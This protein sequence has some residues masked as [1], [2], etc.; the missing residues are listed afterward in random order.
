MSAKN[1]EL[2]R[3]KLLDAG[4]EEIYEHGF[5]AASLDSILAR[6]GVTKGALYHHF[7]NKQALGYALVEE[8]LAEFMV[9]RMSVPLKNSDYPIGALQR[10]G[11][12]MVNEHADDAC[13]H[14]CPLNNLAQEMSSEDEEFRKRIVKLYER[15]QGVVEAAL[16]RGQDAGNVRQDIDPTRIAEFYIAMSMGIMGAAKTSQ[17]PALMRGLIETA[18]HF[19]DSLRPLS[20]N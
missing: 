18:N 1:P 2:T 10:H 6:A 11:L 19:L 17:D 9:E 13:T 8:V 7:P 5:R 3:A 15:L 14:G 16:R 20:V 12:E 4:F